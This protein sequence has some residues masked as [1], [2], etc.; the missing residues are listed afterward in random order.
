MLVRPIRL[1]RRASLPR[2][3]TLRS[4][5]EALETVEEMEILSVDELNLRLKMLRLPSLALERGGRP[6][7][8]ELIEAAEEIGLTP[9]SG[10]RGG[11][12]ER[13]EPVEPLVSPDEIGW[14]PKSRPASGVGLRVVSTC[15]MSAMLDRESAFRSLLERPD[16]F[17]D[18]GADPGMGMDL[19]PPTRSSS[20]P[21]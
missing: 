8:R 11:E 15:W 19:P 2:L 5:T 4:I 3:P 6:L 16:F 9:L 13:V 7:R 17:E 21:P 18:L 20:L 10:V 1:W 14:L 12:V